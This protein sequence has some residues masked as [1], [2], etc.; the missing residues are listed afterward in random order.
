MIP[1]GYAG[2]HSNGRRLPLLRRRWSPFSVAAPARC[3]IISTTP[4]G[5]CRIT[6]VPWR[7]LPGGIWRTVSPRSASPGPECFF[8]R[9][10]GF[11]PDRP[12]RTRLFATYLHR[13]GRFPDAVAEYQ[14]AEKK[15]DVSAELFYN[16]GLLHLDM[17]NVPAA[18]AD[19]ERAYALGYPLP[20]LKNKLQKL[21]AA[22]APS[23]QPAASGNHGVAS[24]SIRARSGR[25]LVAGTRALSPA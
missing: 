20:G 8:R 22:R 23:R 7:L 19:A 6:I 4:C 1:T 15:G 17:G 21:P 2:V 3:R 12:D 9:A 25:R 5:T 14:A 24:R 13:A 18:R 11:T 16:R 10:I